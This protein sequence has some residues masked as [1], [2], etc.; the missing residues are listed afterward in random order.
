MLKVP[1]PFPQVGSYAVHIDDTLP[2]AQ[3]RAE[4]VRIL[5][6]DEQMALV[7]YPLR[8]GSSGNRRVALAELT[9]GT[10]LTRD[11]Q[12]ELADLQRHLRGRDRLRGGQVRQAK[13]CDDLRKRAIWSM[14]LESERAKLA[15]LD[16][17]AQPSTG[18]PLPREIAA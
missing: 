12:R 15:T 4:L 5:E 6:I 8:E 3:Q 11:E 13:R 1:T 17:R 10:P 16:A 18:R 14:V 2:L 7:A 9:D